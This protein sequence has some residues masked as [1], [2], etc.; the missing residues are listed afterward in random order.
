MYHRWKEN[1]ARAV[2]ECARRG[3][4][5]DVSVPADPN[6]A[7]H[8]PKSEMSKVSFLVYLHGGS[9]RVYFNRLEYVIRE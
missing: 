5:P 7:F 9:I 8:R 2:L 4:V 3:V 6:I 1:I